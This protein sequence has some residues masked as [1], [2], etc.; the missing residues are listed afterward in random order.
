LVI[1]IWVTERVAPLVKCIDDA[2]RQVDTPDLEARIV[3]ADRGRQTD[4][5]EADDAHCESS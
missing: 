2:L 4:I 1:Q 3:E 5:A